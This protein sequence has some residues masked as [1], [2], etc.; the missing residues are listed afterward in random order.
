MKRPGYRE[1]I[2][3]IADNDDCYWL[4]DYD[5][6]GPMLS[7]C[8]AM[9]RDLYGV[10]DARLLRD[11]LRALERAGHPVVSSMSAATRAAI[12]KGA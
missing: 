3:W 7:V 5:A 8:A 10:S 12:L 11:I 6:H 9:V 2:E 1:A 4:G